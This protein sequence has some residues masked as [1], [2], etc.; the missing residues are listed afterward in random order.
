MDKAKIPVPVKLENADEARKA[1][2]GGIS[3]VRQEARGDAVKAAEC[4]PTMGVAQD[5]PV[6]A[7]DT[8]QI[9]DEDKKSFVRSVLGNRP[10]SKTF[11]LFGTVRVVFTDRVPDATIEMYNAAVKETPTD[12]PDWFSTLNRYCLAYT[13]TEIEIERKIDK[14]Q[15]T[16]SDKMDYLKKLSR[17]LYLALLDVSDDFE[18]LVNALVDK[19]QDRD[20]WQ[21]GG[22]S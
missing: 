17:P 20:F 7:D 10:F 2:Y 18:Q 9:T 12:S 19:A 21:A 5:I 13:L 8:P 22:S 1:M 15:M 14:L 11:M 3:E 6:L 4:P 16:A